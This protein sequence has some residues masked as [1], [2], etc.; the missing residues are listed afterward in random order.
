M[1]WCTGHLKRDCPK[2]DEIKM[3]E[4]RHAQGW[5]YAVGNAE[6]MRG[7]AIGNP[8]AKCRHGAPIL[9]SLEEIEDFVVYC[10][11]S[12]KGLGVV[13]MQREKLLRAKPETR[14]VAVNE[15]VGGYNPKGYTQGNLGNHVVA[16]WNY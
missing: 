7:I 4:M 13:L 6:K 1:V 2:A 10:D 16:R 3:E 8:D 14:N 11:A 12:H 5:V 15:V 9:A